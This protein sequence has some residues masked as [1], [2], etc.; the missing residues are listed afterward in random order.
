MNRVASLAHEMKF[1][2]WLRG[3]PSRV[4]RAQR[5]P[6]LLSASYWNGG[7]S[8]A[9]KVRDISGTGAYLH[10]P[11]RW[12]VGTILNVTL[13]CES[14]RNA[15]EPGEFVSVPCRVVRQG[16]DGMGVVFMFA[17]S[18][19]RKAVQHFIERACRDM[20][21]PA[22][23]EGGQ[24]LI[25]F[26]LMIPLIFLLIFNAVNFG[27]FLYSWIAISNAARVGVQDVALGSAYA[28][29][30]PTASLSNV[31]TLVQNETASL[32]GTSP[33]VTVCQTHSG[34]WIVYPLSS[35]TT[36]CTLTGLTQDAE[37]ITG[38]AGAS[39]YTTVVVDV[40]Y[41]YTPLLG[42]FGTSFLSGVSPPTTVHRRTTMRLLN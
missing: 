21:V 4:P 11:E 29:Y 8:K 42:N 22:R 31:Q 1:L 7:T 9:V 26:A 34:S 17:G 37:T 19:D 18:Q 39:P 30:P 40:S 27:G 38:L 24:A 12:Y 3:E 16:E 10:A 2:E 32:P 14:G 28:S 41:T 6:C 25:E 20:K 36:A 23:G 15:A 33:T 5:H 13:Q 35:T